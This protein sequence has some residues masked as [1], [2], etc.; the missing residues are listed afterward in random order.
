MR[1][2]P[3]LIGLST[4]II[5]GITTILL[6]TPQ[7]GQ[8]LRSNIALN[9][10]KAKANLVEIAK[11]TSNLKDATFTLK[12]EVQNNIP[13][14][15]HELKD[16]VSNFKQTIEPDAVK[17]KEELEGL[18]NSIAKIENNLSEINNKKSDPPQIQ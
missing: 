10:K 4:G 6:T 14:V 18:Q 15:I 8:Q 7:S 2:K 13:K 1:A 16:S 17:L 5:G 11:H 12:N 9:T 3:F